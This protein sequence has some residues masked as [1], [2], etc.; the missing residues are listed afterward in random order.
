MPDCLNVDQLLHHP[1]SAVFATIVPHCTSVLICLNTSHS[2]SATSRQKHSAVWRYVLHPLWGFHGHDALHLGSCLEPIGSGPNA[3][4]NL[5]VWAVRLRG[6]SP[7]PPVP[8]LAELLRTSTHTPAPMASL[9]PV[10][11]Q[12]DT[13]RFTDTPSI[14]ISTLP[15]IASDPS[16]SFATNRILERLP[17][18]RLN[19][20]LFGRHLPTT[21]I[22]TRDLMSL[23]TMSSVPRPPGITT[24]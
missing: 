4:S 14:A 1:E 21:C 17:L 15:V 22:P 13:G 7:E 20:G 3:G 6:D 23:P 19:I 10:N 12:C 16:A 9:L 18:A 11:I 24:A 2:E 5:S 8:H